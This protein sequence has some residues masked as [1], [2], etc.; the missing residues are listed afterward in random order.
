MNKA[1]IGRRRFQ[2]EI[3]LYQAGQPFRKFLFV[4]NKVSYCRWPFKQAVS[5]FTNLLVI[6]VVRQ[7]TRR[8][9]RQAACGDQ[10]SAVMSK[11]GQLLQRLQGNALHS[12][13]DD[14]WISSRTKC[15]AAFFYMSD[16][17]ER[18]IVEKIKIQASLKYL[19]HHIRANFITEGFDQ[20][21]VV[22]RKMG[23]RITVR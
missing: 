1:E 15:Q 8:Q 16:L 13:K 5:E 18:I 4:S 22:G 10:D 11:F 20:V 12:G 21:N 17:F 7:K 2:R 23:P 9:R 3:N 14:H 19:R 6:G